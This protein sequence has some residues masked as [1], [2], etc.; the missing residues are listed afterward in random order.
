MCQQ[1]E[2]F[3]NTVA[4]IVIEGKEASLVGQD[5]SLLVVRGHHSNK[6]K[7][8]KNH[9]RNFQFYWNNS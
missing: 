8:L 7:R 4:Q 9:S 6:K 2:K 5:R 3:L 1:S